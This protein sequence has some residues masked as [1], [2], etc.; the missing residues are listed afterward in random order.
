[1]VDALTA[2][3]GDYAT[4]D[5]GDVGSWVREGAMR[6]LPDLVAAMAAADA[7]A[8]GTRASCVGEHR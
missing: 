4:D 5:R 1:V 6:A 3:L 2:A 8:P 7:A